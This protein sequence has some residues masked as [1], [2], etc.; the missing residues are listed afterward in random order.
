MGATSRSSV[1]VSRLTSC[2]LFLGFY[3]ANCA[4]AQ[5]PSGSPARRTEQRAPQLQPNE[6]FKLVSPSVFTVESI[7]KDGSVT[8]LGSGVAV[9]PNRIVTNVHVIDDGDS[10]RVKQGNKS[11]SAIPVYADREHDLCELEVDGLHTKGIAVRGSS[12]LEIGERVYAIGTPQGL[13][14]TLS[15]GLISGI[16]DFDHSRAIQTTAA[17]S[18]GSSGGGLFDSGGRL[19]GI[20]TFFVKEGQNLNFALPADIID[21][22]PSHPYAKT[23]AVESQDPLFQA[24]VWTLAGHEFLKQKKTDQGLDAFQQAIRVEPDFP[25]AWAGLG[26][27]YEDLNEDSQAAKAYEEAVRLQ[28][29]APVYWYSLGLTY[30]RLSLFDQ[31]AHAYE[32]AVALKPDYCEPLGRLGGFY[33]LQGERAKVL[34]VYKKLRA[35]NCEQADEFFRLFVLPSQD[36]K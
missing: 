27:A 25:G 16:R 12:T 4:F 7:A 5:T 3:F 35:S 17:I 19:V 20:T 29:N 36:R 10:W 24:L 13:E 14:V 15:D 31:A 9:A 30:G 28:P 18:K 8:T 22:L 11:W 26:L 33:V 21:S 32:Q 23:P 1:N 34:D 6:L 2:V